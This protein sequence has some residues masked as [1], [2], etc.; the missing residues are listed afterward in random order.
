MY[1]NNF[2]L[3]FINFF[4]FFKMIHNI[5][6]INLIEKFNISLLRKMIYQKKKKKKYLNKNK[7]ILILMILIKKI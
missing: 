4:F 2:Y 5:L 7:V 1:F 6:F 3:Y